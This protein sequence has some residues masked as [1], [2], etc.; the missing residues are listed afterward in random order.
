[1]HV[2]ALVTISLA[3]LHA[4]VDPAC[5]ES[6]TTSEICVVTDII[7]GHGRYLLNSSICSMGAHKP[8]SNGP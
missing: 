5:R 1:M 4:A 6:N 3:S 8:I 2:F 7:E